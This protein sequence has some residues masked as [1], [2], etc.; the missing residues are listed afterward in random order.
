MTAVRQVEFSWANPQDLNK[1]LACE[2]SFGTW[3]FHPPSFY[4]ESIAYGRVLVAWDGQTA[5]AY[6]IYEVIWGNTA[7]LSLLKVLPAYQRNG[8]GKTMIAQL[9]QR[10]RKQRFGSYVTSSDESNQSTKRLFPSLGFA[11]IGKLDMA[12]GGETFYLKH[13]T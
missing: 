6:L 12:H 5:V 7:F 8:I 13:L 1:I 11:N 2:K 4:E 10:L 3:G 9:E